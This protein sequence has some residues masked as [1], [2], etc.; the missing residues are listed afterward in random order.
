M[1]SIPFVLVAGIFAALQGA[2]VKTGVETMTSE[3]IF[4]ARYFIGFFLISAWTLLVARKNIIEHVV[5]T[6]KIKLMILRATTAG[7][8]SYCYYLAL[9]HTTLSSAT[10]L[11]QTIPVFVPFVARFWLKIKIHGNSWWGLSLALIGIALILK[12]SGNFFNYGALFGLGSGVLGSISSVS[13]RVLHRTE[14]SPKILWYTFLLASLMGV[15]LFA[16]S[17]FYVPFRPSRMDLLILGS[18]GIAG[19]LFQS[20]FVVAVRFSP[21][22]LVT[23]FIYF[24]LIFTVLLDFFYY[25]VKPDFYEVIG[26]CL[27]ILGVV[28]VVVLF[29]KEANSK[30]IENGQR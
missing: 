15:V 23:P 12:P 30:P 16:I 13:A 9:R 18:I 28:L 26:I 3:T 27:V 29:P 11:F 5:K 7:A 24:S 21:A 1:I 14:S 17:S 10:I 22:R 6:H 19:V 8:A 20:L 25:K 2:F 4:F